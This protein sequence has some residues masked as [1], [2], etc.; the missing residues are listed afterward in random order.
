MNENQNDN[1]NVKT[2]CKHNHIFDTTSLLK[3]NLKTFGLDFKSY[4]AFCS[5][6]HF[7]M[8]VI[9]PDGDGVII[10][11]P[12]INYCPACGARLQPNPG[13]TGFIRVIRD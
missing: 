3:K 5:T 13:F 6:G 4:I 11:F 9:Y 7:E 2:P 10:E 8:R 1:E 12:K